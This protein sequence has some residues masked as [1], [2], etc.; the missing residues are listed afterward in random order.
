L[1]FTNNQFNFKLTK[2]V[3]SDDKSPN[4]EENIRKI[5]LRIFIFYTLLTLLIFV[6]F[7]ISGIRLF[8]GL[9]LTT[10]LISSGGFLP[11]NSLNQIIKTT[12]QEIFLIFSFLISMLN[13]LFLYNLFSEKSFFKKQYEDLLIIILITFFSILLLLFV[14]DLNIFHS[15]IYVI[16]SISTSGI[17]IGKIDEN[18]SLYLLFLTIIGG[19]VISTTSGIKAIRIYILV[20]ASFAEII[21]W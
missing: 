3:F 16:S 6:L 4:L 12:T 17:S 14:K 2:L 10:T 18:F 8:N 15:T 7:T 5:S 19:S 21:N 1:F 20:K 13:I 9:N 11:T